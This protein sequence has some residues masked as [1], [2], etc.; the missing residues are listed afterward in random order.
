MYYA[1]S[2]SS[3]NCREPATR[4]IVFDLN[5]CQVETYMLILCSL[6][7]FKSNRL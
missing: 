1:C 4:E 5:R 3:R 6:P 7:A 2:L